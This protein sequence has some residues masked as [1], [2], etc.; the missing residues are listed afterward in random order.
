MVVVNGHVDVVALVMVVV[1]ED[2]ES[3]MT[4]ELSN[5]QGHMIISDFELT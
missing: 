2:K 3:R 4:S 5:Q 1:V